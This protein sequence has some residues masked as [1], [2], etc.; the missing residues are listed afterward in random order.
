ME[1]TGD[2]VAQRRLKMTN[3]KTIGAALLATSASGMF[4]IVHKAPAVREQ[5]TLSQKKVV[6]VTIE[7]N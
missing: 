6:S 3:Q 2:R 7:S 4:V 1:A 5:A